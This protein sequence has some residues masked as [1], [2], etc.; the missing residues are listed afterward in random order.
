MQLAVTGA[1]PDLVLLH[2][3]GMRASVWVDLAALL[4]A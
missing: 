2:G 3:W 1:G 4:A